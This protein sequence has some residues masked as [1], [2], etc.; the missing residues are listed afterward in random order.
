[1]PKVVSGKHIRYENFEILTEMGPRG[2]RIVND[3]VTAVLDRLSPV[4]VRNI[5]GFTPVFTGESKREIKGQ[6][7]KIKNGWMLHVK[8]FKL[9]DVRMNSIESGRKP[10]R[11]PPWGARTPLGRWAAAK[12]IP[13][14]LVARA[15]A[16]RGTIKRFRYKGAEMFARGFNKSKGRINSEMS[17]LEKG[18]AR[19]LVSGGH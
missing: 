18:I 12:G 1:M 7:S 2:R 19:K 17:R 4:L 11:M 9:K 6:Q 3:E 10:G 16:R 5:A 14:F 8:A 13:A 15:I